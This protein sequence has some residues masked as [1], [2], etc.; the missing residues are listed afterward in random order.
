MRG[1]IG[2]KVKN[3]DSRHPRHWISEPSAKKLLPRDAHSSVGKRLVVEPGRERAQIAPAQDVTGDFGSASAAGKRQG[4]GGGHGQALPWMARGMLEYKYHGCVA[5]L[6]ARPMDAA[7]NY[8]EGRFRRSVDEPRRTGFG[9]DRHR[10]Y[11][12]ISQLRRRHRRI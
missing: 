3:K 10:V 8:R 12:D 7:I 5:R 9:T 6:I 2:G 4:L 11:S 1:K